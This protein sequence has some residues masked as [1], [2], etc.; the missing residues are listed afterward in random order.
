MVAGAP[1]TTSPSPEEVIK[2]GKEMLAWV[3]EKNPIHIKQWY[4]I[5]KG[6]IYKDWKALIQLKEFLP[7]YEQALNIISLKYIDK[8]SEI[9]DSVAHRFLRV[10][11]KDVKDEEDETA[12]FLE[13]LKKDDS[14]LI[15][16]AHIEGMEAV[17]ALMKQRQSSARKTEE[18]SNN[19]DTK[20]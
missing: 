10:Y 11:Y 17:L 5:E 20:S 12:K 18:I 19:S 2:L 14:N 16:K 3:K 4:S 8:T 7:Y 9:R 6:I 13:D 15:D 1:R